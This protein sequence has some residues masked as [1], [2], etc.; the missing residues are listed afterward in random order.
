MLY[1]VGNGK[2]TINFLKSKN[3]FEVDKSATLKQVSDI[4]LSHDES[5]APVKVNEPLM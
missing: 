4:I 3:S 2:F 5:F 1:S